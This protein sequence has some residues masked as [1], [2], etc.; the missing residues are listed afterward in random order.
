MWLSGVTPHDLPSTAAVSLSCVKVSLLAAGELPE[1]ME[2]LWVFFFGRCDLQSCAPGF[3]AQPASG[4][5]RC[6]PT[7]QNSFVPFYKV[8]CVALLKWT[9][10]KRRN[11]YYRKK[12]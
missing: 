11:L 6:V 1:E 3:D 12:I 7:M 2:L 8:C 4:D 9:C 5:V 10:C